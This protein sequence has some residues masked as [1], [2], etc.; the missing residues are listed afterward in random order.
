MTVG[1][2]LVLSIIEGITE[3]LPVSSTGHLILAGSLLG[4][5]STDTVKSFELFIQLGAISAVV[6]LY[7][8]TILSNIR[9]WKVLA[10]AFL[11]TGIIGLTLYKLIKS[12]LLGN[13][14]ITVFALGIGGIAI[15]AFETWHPA[16]KKSN[17]SPTDLAA[18]RP[19][20]A[21]WIGVGQSLAMIPGVSRSAATIITGM[22]TGL[23]RTQAV[24][25]SF[26]L[27]IPTM[28]FATGYDLVKTADQLSFQDMPV[29]AV[30]FFGAFVT[31]LITI[32]WFL[33]YVS[34]HTLAPFGIYRIALALAYLAFM[35]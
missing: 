12:V 32:R 34:G 5:L 9:L 7:A 20:Q 17:Q 8:R 25:F 24:E 35:R 30:G 33:R 22:L 27:A 19:V 10:I 3:F 31:A 23:S 6:V 13:P 4:I 16:A 15:I 14:L 1:M 21:L 18:M 29:F 11:P 2:A 26:L 28:A